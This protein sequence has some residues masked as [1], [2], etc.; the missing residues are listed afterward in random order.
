MF[1]GIS[2]VLIVI[3]VVGI[4]LVIFVVDGLVFDIWFFV[5]ELIELGISVML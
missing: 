4:G 2:S 3:G 1:G 5:L